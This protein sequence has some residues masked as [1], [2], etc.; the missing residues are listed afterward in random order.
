M[1]DEDVPLFDQKTERNKRIAVR[2][3]ALMAEGKHGHYET[4]FRVVQEEIE[5]VKGEIQ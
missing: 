4:M 1:N 3:D 2:Y 5:R